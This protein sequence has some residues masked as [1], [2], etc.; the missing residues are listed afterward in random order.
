MPKTDGPD[1][2]GWMSFVKHLTTFCVGILCV[3]LLLGAALGMKPLEARAVGTLPHDSHAV[4]IEWPAVAGGG[5]TWLPKADQETLT[6]L[7]DD[8]FGG[9]PDP[10]S[11]APLESLSRALGASGWFDGLPSAR[12]APGGRIEV[13]G[14]WRIPAAVV[15]WNAKDYLLSWD[16]MPMPAVYEPGAAR[17]PVIVSPALGPPA[18]PTGDRDLQTAWAGEDVGAALELLRVVAGQKWSDQVRGVDLS[19]YSAEGVL[20]IVTGENARVVWGGRPSRPRLGEVTTAQK[21]VHLSQLYHD[22]KRIDA[23]YPLLYI[24]S[25]RIQLDSSATARTMQAP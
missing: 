14:S 23:G 6:R 22:H 2:F 4:S 19:R 5:G 8:A 15:R 21:L 11:P 16:A 10:F 17:L 1:K 12:R 7:A 9:D 25:Q 20:M 13:R 3:G 24:N 18:L